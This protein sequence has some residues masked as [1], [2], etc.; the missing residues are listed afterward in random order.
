MLCL[1]VIFVPASD[2]TKPK[3][4]LLIT[5][6][7]LRADR[8]SCYDSRH[9]PTPH[10]DRLAADGA[11]FKRAFAHNPLTL[12]SHTNILLGTTPL[13]HGV[14]DNVDFIVKKEQLSLAEFLK[15]KG[16]ATA[17]VIGATPLDSRFGLDQGF[18]LYDDSFTEPGSPKFTEGERKAEEVA[19]IAQKWLAARDDPWFLWMHIF[20]PHYS[21]E[22]PEPFLSRYKN[23]PYDGEVAYVDSVLGDFFNFMKKAGL[24]DSTLIIF[25]A[26][27]GE[28]LGEHEE[29]THGIL[30]YNST[31]WIPLIIHCPGLKPLEIEQNVCHA[32][33]FPTVC[34]ILGINPPSFL[35]GASLLPALRGKKLKDRTI[36]FESLEPHYR[37]DWAPLKG[38]I[39][40][41]DKFIDSPVPELYDLGKDFNETANLASQINLSPF[42]NL[43]TKHMEK[44]SSHR[45]E[46]GARANLDRATLER[47]RSLGYVKN[48]AIN[49]KKEYGPEDDVKSLLPLHNRIVAAYRLWEKG[50]IDKGIEMLEKLI[51]EDDR[52]DV[53]YSHL[54]KLYREKGL[55]NDAITVL[56]NGQKNHPYSYEILSLH[57]KIL[58]E[59]GRYNESIQLLESKKLLQMGQDP[60]L[61]NHL[62]VALM[63]TGKTEKAVQAFEKALEIDPEYADV[64][65]N[66]GS[67]Y[68]ARFLQTKSSDARKQAEQYLDKTLR[69]DSRHA[70][71][72]N[73]RGVL[74]FQDGKIRQAVTNWEQ[75]VKYDPKLFKTFYY[76]G[77]AY[78][79]LGD[80][81]KAAEDLMHYKD[82]AYSRLSPQEK[83]RLDHLLELV[84]DGKR[85]YPHQNYSRSDRD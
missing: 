29:Q 40:K 85:D 84:K 69:L 75:A 43:L 6:D 24:Y 78:Y 25:T 38:I 7:T 1:L 68:L 31:L 2:E 45:A 47:L 61:W 30:A 35:E 71:G 9:V 52:I 50:Q 8:L 42:K 82:A 55:I 77:V 26:D 22:P 16:F 76:L 62:G 17:A 3:N 21:Y 80:M 63:N 39:L 44:Y 59:T 73:S 33:I 53:A 74:F 72:Y 14:S 41:N 13:Q 12:P 66:L 48:P 64:A 15:E 49:R 54:A 18:D 4:I 83:E 20:D 5:I 81:V 19:A 70:N 37:M 58:I 67:I 79:N 65:Y 51:K 60:L 34:G 56:Q 32:D 10:I 11:V 57:S 23:R 28:S 36:Y 27:H 46:E